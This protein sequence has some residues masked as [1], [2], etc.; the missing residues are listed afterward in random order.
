MRIL[1]ILLLCIGTL[2]ADSIMAGTVHGRVIAAEVQVPGASGGGG[3]YGSRKFK[4]VDR[5]DYKSFHGFVVY[6]DGDGLARPDHGSTATIEQRDATFIPDTLVIEK[7]TTV[8]WPNLDEI[9]HNVFSFSPVKPFDLG[10]Y[11]QGE[12]K[13]LLFDRAGVV[14]VYCAIHDGMH[15]TIVVLENSFFDVTDEDGRYAIQN[16]P[17]GRYRLTAWHRSLPPKTIEIEVRNGESYEADFEL[18]L[19]NLPKY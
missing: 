17:D 10:M 4:F 16:V 9:Y 5:I 19:Q 6:L 15:A 2:A 11:K 3:G 18:G 12:G 7:G 8:L 13:K 1:Q 14:D